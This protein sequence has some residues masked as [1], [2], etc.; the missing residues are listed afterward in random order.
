MYISVLYIKKRFVKEIDGINQV[1]K[2][3]LQMLE[4]AV[5]KHLKYFRNMI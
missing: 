1:V 3:T 4:R 2:I 5:F